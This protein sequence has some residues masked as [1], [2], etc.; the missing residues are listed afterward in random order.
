MGDLGHA[1]DGQDSTED[2]KLKEKGIKGDSSM[3]RSRK[4]R[5]GRVG[6]ARWAVILAAG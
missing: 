5:D 1:L 3:S 2:Q 4:R 6:A